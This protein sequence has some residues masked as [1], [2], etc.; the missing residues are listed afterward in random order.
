M[1]PRATSSYFQPRFLSRSQDAGSGSQEFLGIS[2]AYVLGEVCHQWAVNPFRRQLV[3]RRRQL[4]SQAYPD[5]ASKEKSGNAKHRK[6]CIE[7]TGH[8]EEKSKE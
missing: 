1:R 6:S 4:E 2:G 5:G 7:W 8:D 3:G